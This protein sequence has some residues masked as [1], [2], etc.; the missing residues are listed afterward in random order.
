MSRMQ[1]SPAAVDEPQADGRGSP[2]ENAVRRRWQ[3]L[4]DG[5]RGRLA[6]LDHWLLHGVRW[7]P[8]QRFPDRWLIGSV[9]LFLLLLA[10]NTALAVRSVADIGGREREI[11]HSQSVLTAIR[12]IAITLDDAETGQ[13]GYILTGDSDYLAPYK[14]AQQS[15]NTQLSLLDALTAHDPAQQVSES[16]LRT[17][18]AAK[19]TEM[20]QTIALRQ[21]GHT[22]QALQLVLSGQGKTTMDQIRATLHTMQQ[23]ENATLD[24][25]A[26]QANRSL[27]SAVGTFIAA[28]LA[29]VVLLIFVFLLFRLALAQREAAKQQMDDFLSIA[30]HELKTPLTTMYM[31]VQLAEGY[32]AEISADQS[33]LR[34]LPRLHELY[35]TNEQQMRRMMA[36]LNDLLDVSRLQND[37]LGLQVAACDLAELARSETEAQRLAVPTRALTVDVP[38][39]PVLVQADPDRLR[40]VI[41]NFIVNAIKYSPPPEPVAVRLV[42]DGRQARLEVRD[43][44]PG[45]PPAMRQRIWERF[46]RVP[47]TEVQF[48]SGVGLGLGLFIC[49]RI[50]V[51]HQGRY[52]VEPAPDHGAIFWFALPLAE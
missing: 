51:A 31:S 52:G 46:Q 16:D 26:A 17:M 45:V 28:S 7:D 48:G 24:R 50:I 15:I 37:Q 44:G 39:A 22:N 13:R 1:D 11:Q 38:P 23:T 10:G 47:G 14:S 8:L 33:N 12:N 9:V 3:A 30:S 6:R 34:R 18:V 21:Q 19:F 41:A 42:T 36:L 35:R 25:H 43:G 32:L 5:G 29:D 2:N 20:Q 27:E 40:Q 49:Q 4:A